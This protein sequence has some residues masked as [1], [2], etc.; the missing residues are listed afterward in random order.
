M[1]AAAAL[2]LE[3]DMDELEAQSYL[4]RIRREHRLPDLPKVVE[5]LRTFVIEGNGRSLADIL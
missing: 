1:H 4:I 2:L 3:M 5:N